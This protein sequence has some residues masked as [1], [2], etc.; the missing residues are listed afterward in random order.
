M[1]VYKLHNTVNIQLGKPEWK[2]DY[3]YLRGSMECLRARCSSSIPNRSK[4][5]EKGCTEPKVCPVEVRLNFQERQQQ[6]QPVCKDALKFTFKDERN[7]GLLN[8]LQSMP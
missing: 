3:E 8:V 5:K 7:I 4:S 6:T 1:F 2:H